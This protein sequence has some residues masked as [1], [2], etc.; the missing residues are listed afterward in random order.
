[1]TS[2][3][4]TK[5]SN[6]A[7][8]PVIQVSMPLAMIRGDLFSVAEKGERSD[9]RQVA[10][11]NGPLGIDVQY[12]GPHLNQEHFKAWQ[13]VIYLAKQ[14]GG[15]SGEQ[16]VVSATDVMRAMGQTY[17]D[18]DQRRRAWRLLEDLSQASVY[19][20]SNRSRYRGALVFSVL[21][22]EA[23]G[24]MALRLNPD[25]AQLLSNEVLQNDM[26]RVLGLGRNQIAIWLH[27][28]YASHKTPPAI[29]VK[30]LQRLCGTKL[31][32]PRFRQRLRTALDRLKS[33]VRPLLTHWEIDAND[34]VRVKKIPTQVKL[35]PAHVNEAKAAHNGVSGK[36]AQAAARRA[37]VAL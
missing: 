14:E 19:L 12:S 5:K 34:M 7:A 3:S 16:F 24:K 10:V 31:D 1:M 21:H 11:E 22:E 36:A 35:L 20:S 32:L 28:Y 13:A 4:H 18:H 23:S 26:L 15:L 29:S 9:R 25:L 33:G 17:R 6:P 8:I 30:E 2:R 37:Q 27:N